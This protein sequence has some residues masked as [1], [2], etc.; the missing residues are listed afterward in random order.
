[1]RATTHF[2]RI[3]R[4]GKAFSP[5]HNDRSYDPQKKPANVIAEK[6][7][8][9]VIHYCY[10]DGEPKEKIKNFEDHEKWVYQNYLG[11]FF[12]AQN[13]R[14]K[15]SRHLERIKTLDQFRKM[16]RY[17]PEEVLWYVGRK[18]NSATPE[19]LQILAEKQ[20]QWEEDKYPG[21][22][23]LDWAVHVDELGAPH[24][25]A[26]R[27]WTYNKNGVIAI[28]QNKAL[29]QMG[30]ELPDPTQPI[31]E[32][33]NRKITY[34]AQTREHWIDQA[35]NLFG[36]NITRKPSGNA[37]KT[38]EEWQKEQDLAQREK[39]LSEAEID[40]SERSDALKREISLTNAQIDD[41]NVAAER[42]NSA[43][44]FEKRS[45]EA[46]A[47]MMKAGKFTEKTPPKT[48][49][50][51]IKTLAQVFDEMKN[52]VQKV[53]RMPLDTLIAHCINAKNKGCKNLEEYFF[54]PI[55]SRNKIKSK[56]R[57]R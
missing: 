43:Q 40:L 27:I 37:G 32:K 35:E 2:G 21:L 28:G 25:Q 22:K 41:F 17:C 15:K 29:D 3:T 53:L 52:K 48:L 1:M 54:P 7:K 24:V 9:N 51:A 47:E 16:P 18:G 19:Q 8:D 13:E 44:S 50:G 14:N 10:L 36:Y 20:I 12:N 39:T 23:Y 49:I 6:S 55:E 33:N 56:T 45:A 42:F 26:R 34:T 57:S 31:S 46:V 30:V 38:L 11:E 5:K 4:E